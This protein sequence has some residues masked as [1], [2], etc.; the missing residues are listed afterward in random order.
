MKIYTYIMTDD[1]SFAPNPY[2]GLCTLA[3]CKPKIRKAVANK[4]LDSFSQRIKKQ[5]NR[6]SL[7]KQFVNKNNIG[8]LQGI[9]DY[10][11]NSTL[12]SFKSFSEFVKSLEI[13]VVGIVGSNLKTD[14][15]KEGSIVYIM[16]VTDIVDFYEYW[17]NEAYEKKKPDKEYF[18]NNR[19]DSFSYKNCG[20]NIYEID[21]DNPTITIHHS[22]HY[23]EGEDIVERV[24]HDL[25]GK[26]VLLSDNFVYYGVN[27]TKYKD[28]L[29]KGIGHS[30][31]ENNQSLEQF[32][33]KEL[34]D[35]K[36]KILGRPINS[37]E[38]FKWDK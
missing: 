18:K 1:Y 38:N 31:L 29:H 4:I 14:T 13:Y 7:T 16:Q 23:F 10:C 22:F 17:N 35:N 33:L 2:F 11:N 24:S 26:Y 36:N 28:E 25:S 21:S 8:S 30:L 37:D 5:H 12:N 32:I 6:K 27:A 15:V 19:K 3:C 20:D 9:K 34:K